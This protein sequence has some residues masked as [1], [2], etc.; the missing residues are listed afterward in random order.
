M[1]I[2]ILIIATLALAWAN[3]ANDTGKPLA[4]LVA[5]GALNER[6]A[7]RWAA[8]AGLVGSCAALWLGADLA[9]LF[10][11]SGIIDDPTRH[12]DAFAPAVAGGAA[13]AVLLASR[14]GLP[15]S[16]THALLGALVGTGLTLHGV[17]TW[18]AVGIKIVMPLLVSP[19]LAVVMSLLLGVIVRHG[20]SYL[21]RSCVCTVTAAMPGGQTMSTPIIGELST[22]TAAGA[23]PMATGAGV[24]RWLHMGSGLAIAV[25]RGLN[26]T[27]KIAALILPI[28]ILFPAGDTCAIAAIGLLIALGGWLAGRRVMQVMATK[29]VHLEGKEAEAGSANLTAAVLILAASPAGLPVSTTHVTTGALVGAGALAGGLSGRWLGGILFAWLTTLPL[30]AVAAAGLALLLQW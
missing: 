10:T 9:R 26:D 22:C 14:F 27:P 8:A 2:V 28:A 20:A 25:A 13:I 11:G 3:G 12:A 23:A 19:M 15:V 18:S 5:A 21:G 17:I 4:S 6:R 24:G 29:L 7:L 30:A 16:T 1:I